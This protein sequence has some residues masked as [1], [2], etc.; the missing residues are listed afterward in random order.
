MR[1]RGLNQ[2]INNNANSDAWYNQVA[3]YVANP[4]L[5]TLYT[6]S[7][8]SPPLP[9][10]KTIFACPTAPRPNFTPSVNKAFFMYGMN[11][12]LCVNKSTRSSMGIRNTAL[13][14]IPNPSDT[15]FLAESDGNSATAGIA[16][17]NV[18]G[19]YAVGRHNQRGVFAM[20]DGSAR[21]AGPNDYLRSSAE[22]NSAQSEW[23]VGRS[24]Y[25]YPNSSTPN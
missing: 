24:M 21:M 22:S 13:S 18:T 10:D 2:A 3:P 12:R 1:V 16:Q 17:S 11:G 9:G 6:Q 7:P 20:T 25:W 23:S 15:I 19:Q 8:S 5:V 14:S 4:S